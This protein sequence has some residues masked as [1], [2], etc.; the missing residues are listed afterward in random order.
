MQKLKEQAVALLS[1][2]SEFTQPLLRL[3][4][5]QVWLGRG[6]FGGAQ[7]A[8]DPPVICPPHRAQL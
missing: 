3:C 5:H 4:G 6:W 1:C 2:Y 7:G 8:R